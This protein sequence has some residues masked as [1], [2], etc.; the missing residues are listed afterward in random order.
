MPDLPVWLIPVLI[1]L[2]RIADVS[3]G[4]LRIMTVGRGMRALSSI[5]GF[6]EVLIWLA[7]ISQIVNNLTS[8]ENYIAYALGFASGTWIGM[9]IE[10]KLSLGMLLVRVIIPRGPNGLFTELQEK[11]YRVT[12]LDGEG[13]TGP[14]R[15]LFTI[16]KRSRLNK[17]MAIIKAHDPNAYYSVE[18][19]RTATDPVASQ[20]AFVTKYPTILQPFNW[21]RKGK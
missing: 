6:F 9:T 14:V 15:I 5:L 13:A 2:A 3:I 12:A 21:F 11:E 10:R 8:W 18:D 17:L 19:V 20:G 4:T 7:A 1:F 16:V